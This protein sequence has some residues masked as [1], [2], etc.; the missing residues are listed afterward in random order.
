MIFKSINPF[1]Q[2]LIAEIPSLK[3]KELVNRLAVSRIAFADWKETTV[4]ER[5]KLLVCLAEVIEN[6][7]DWLALEMA[8]EMGKT[9]TEAKA[10]VLKCGV[11]ARFFAQ[12]AHS[13]LD[14][15]IIVSD[16]RF[17]SV[18]FQPLGGIFLVMPWNFPLWQ[19]LRAA[20]PALLVGNTILVKHAPNVMRFALHVEALFAE[21]GFPNGVYTNL[22]ID[23]SEIERVVASEAVAAVSLTG[24]ERAGR[25]IAGIAGKYLKKCVLELGGSDPFIVMPDAD[26]VQAGKMAAQ[27]RLI[28]NGQSCIAA[29]RF[30]VHESVEKSF[31]EQ[32]VAQLSSCKPGDPI[33]PETQLGPLARKDLADTLERQK[34]QSIEMG[35][36]LHYQMEPF[37]STGFFAL[38][39][40]LTGCKPGMV[41]FDEETFGPLSAVCS[42]S[43]LQEAIDLANQT[44]YGLGATIHTADEAKAQEIALKLDCGTV[45]INSMVRSKP[46]LPFGGVKTSGYGNELSEWGMQEFA[47]VKSIVVG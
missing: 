24:S 46:M 33:L 40:I 43:S 9:F 8:G 23:V 25:S 13:Y 11:G 39:S 18:V 15:R 29:K 1:N 36:R 21:A 34:Q 2:K 10:E 26:L 41:C 28:N 32:F 22:P 12:S 4:N 30:I 45:A 37:A 35:A 38:P 27:A 5:A 31:L 16:A 3:E 14:P 20:I 6:K 7:A 19:I 17:S 42:Y 44:R 47:N